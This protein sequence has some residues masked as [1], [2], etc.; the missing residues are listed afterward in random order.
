MPLKF[1]SAIF[2][3]LKLLNIK[4]MFNKVNSVY[5]KSLIKDICDITESL[6]RKILLIFKFGSFSSHN[7]RV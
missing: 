2:G 6:L 5:I 1:Q 4:K 3:R 7:L